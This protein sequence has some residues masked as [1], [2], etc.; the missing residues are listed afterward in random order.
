MAKPTRLR[1][2]GC[3]Y[4]FSAAD[5]YWYGPNALPAITSDI[6]IVGN[7]ATLTRSGTAAFRFFYVGGTP[8]NI[9][10]GHLTLKNL[11]I[12]N[13]LAK[14]GGSGAGS[15]GGGGGG[16]G[17][18]GAIYNQG[19][20]ALESVTIKGNDLLGQLGLANKQRNA[21]W[22]RPNRQGRGNARTRQPQPDVRRRFQ[23]DHL[24][25]D[26]AGLE[27]RRHLHRDEQHDLRSDPD[28]AGER[29]QLCSD[30]GDR[31][32]Q[33][34]RHGNGH[35]HH[36]QGDGDARARQSG[37]SLQRRNQACDAHGHSVGI[38]CGCDL[39]RCK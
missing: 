20:L 13:G 5:N 35:A 10:T 30:G 3:T 23:A 16:M 18:G 17:A 29:R 27:R 24:H 12:A 38:D 19:V 34:S 15:F 37:S 8:T 21:V 2:S 31:R 39:H 11:T 28:S 14:G 32:D 1:K 4:T 9:P 22:Q 6:T 36:R 33:L 25:H 7:G 26:S